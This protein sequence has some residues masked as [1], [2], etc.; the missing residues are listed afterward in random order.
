MGR[1]G[2][3]PFRR[4]APLPRP[5]AGA[6]ALVLT[7]R[8]RDHRGV[9]ARR[10][11]ERV[12]VS[13]LRGFD[14]AEHQDYADL[15]IHHGH[16]GP[17]TRSEY[18]TPPGSTRSR[19]RLPWSANTFTPGSAQARAVPEL[20]SSSWPR[21]SCRCS[22][23]SS[24]RAPVAPAVRARL[25]LLPA[26]RLPHG[27]DVPSRAVV[28]AADRSPCCSPR[29]FSSAATFVRSCRST[30]HRARR[31]TARP[32][33]LPLDV[34]R[35]RAR[36]RGG[37]VRLSRRASDRARR[38]RGCNR[39]GRVAVVHPTGGELRRSA[40]RPSHRGRGRS[41]S[42]G[43]RLLCRARAARRSSRIRFA[44]TSATKRCRR[45]TARSG[46]TTSASSAGT[47]LMHP[48]RAGSASFGSRRSSASC[49]RCSRSRAGLPCSYRASPRAPRSSRWPCSPGLGH[50]GY[51]YFT[52]SYP[53]PDGDV[54]KASYM[55]TTAP[56]WAL[57]FGYAF[58][59]LAGRGRPCGRRP[60][61]DGR[62]P[63]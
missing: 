1:A 21:R 50:L 14:V 60:R 24:S 42:G 7:S 44:P 47:L 58:D 48:L 6:C 9:C 35:S 51:L 11:L 56:A 31:R 2:S 38:R 61:R 17:E 63:R 34:R 54:L 62:Q 8:R 30:R 36:V 37:H 27:R 23:G 18:Y 15:L 3:R 29:G 5:S 53:T 59:W 4:R 57:A 10:R 19:V 55:L 45:P 26:G 52:V 39:P 46:A 49:P 41:G 28:H 33:V 12:R 22:H 43:P 13:E 25:L 32:R 20:A 16:S 40:L